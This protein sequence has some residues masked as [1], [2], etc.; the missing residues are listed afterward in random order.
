MGFWTVSYSNCIKEACSRQR[1][2]YLVYFVFYLIEQIYRFNR[3][4]IIYIDG[5]EFVQDGFVFLDEEGVGVGLFGFV[6][7]KV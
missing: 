7:G 4:Q 6:F 1:V 3:C 5:G 2:S